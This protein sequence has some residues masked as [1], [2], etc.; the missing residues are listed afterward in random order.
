MAKQPSD[1]TNHHDVSKAA[2]APGGDTNPPHAHP[3]ESIPVRAAKA[4]GFAGPMDVPAQ[5][6]R[7]SRA[8]GTPH[9]HPLNSP[10]D[11]DNESLIGPQLGRGGTQGPALPPVDATY[12]YTDPGFTGDPN[13]KFVPGIDPALSKADASFIDRSDLL[14]RPRKG[15]TTID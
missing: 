15:T 3:S 11:T 7:P 8:A 2:P 9:D 4:S 10:I 5:Q 13:E 1:V 12:I 6:S 14:V